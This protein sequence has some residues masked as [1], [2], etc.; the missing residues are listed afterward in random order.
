MFTPD[1]A[2]A[3]PHKLFDNFLWQGEFS[4]V[5]NACAHDASRVARSMSRSA[6]A[7]SRCAVTSSS[8]AR[9]AT[10]VYSCFMYNVLFTQIPR[11]RRK[12][13]PHGQNAEIL[14]AAAAG[15][16]LHRL[17]V[18][19]EPPHLVDRQWPG[20][21]RR[22]LH[23]CRH[24]NVQ[25]RKCPGASG[26][27]WRLRAGRWHQITLTQ[28]NSFRRVS[29]HRHEDGSWNSTKMESKGR[30]HTVGPLKSIPSPRSV[31]RR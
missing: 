3:L 12:C 27:H 8:A 24:R 1:R 6:I 10:R 13:S 31:F 11:G 19:A 15:V 22:C 16:C 28:R 2:R 30:S 23:A 14:M 4:T 26:Y 20:M 25:R 21:H 5:I 29:V 18:C 9:L 17:A 7:R